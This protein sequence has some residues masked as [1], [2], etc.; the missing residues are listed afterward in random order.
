MICDSFK[1]IIIQSCKTTFKITTWRWGKPAKLMLQTLNN[2][3]KLNNKSNAF[4]IKKRVFAPPFLCTCAVSFLSCP[5]Q[6]WKSILTHISVVSW[7]LLRGDWQQSVTHAHTLLRDV[8]TQHELNY[9]CELFHP[10]NIYFYWPQHMV[11][12]FIRNN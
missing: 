2:I 8:Q 9:M 4:T 10:I 7:D 11:H 12:T 6:M 1:Q 3:K 5:C